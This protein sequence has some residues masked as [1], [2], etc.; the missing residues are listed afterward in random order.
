MAVF[1]GDFVS[2]FAGFATTFFGESVFVFGLDSDVFVVGFETLFIA[3]FEFDGF[4]VDF[5][6]C[7]SLIGEM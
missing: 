3:G 5:E 6:R 2:F 1:V 4:V 7:G